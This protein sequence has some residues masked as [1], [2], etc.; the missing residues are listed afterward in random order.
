VEGVLDL[1]GKSIQTTR[2]FD[3]LKPFMSLRALGRRHFAAMI[4]STVDLAKRTA[5]L[6]DDDPELELVV[7]PTINAIVFRFVANGQTASALDGVNQGIRRKLLADGE[8]LLAGTKVDG[9]SFLKLT[10]LNP[11]TTDAHVRTIL[12]HVKSAG[13]KLLALVPGRQARSEALS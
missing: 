4:D 2:R 3:G 6:I 1:V 13:H 5:A 7:A 12:D 9:R 10:M 8:A 11:R